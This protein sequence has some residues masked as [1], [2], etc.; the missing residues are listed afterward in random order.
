M[1]IML[2]GSFY[3]F[4]GSKQATRGYH[5][6]PVEVV[7][8]LEGGR[9]WVWKNQVNAFLKHNQLYLLFGMGKSVS[10]VY[11]ESH[12]QYVRNFIETGIIGSLVFFFLI[13]MILKK[14][15]HEFARGKD[16]FLVALCAGAFVSTLA[17]LVMAIAAEVFLS[18]KIDEIYWSLT[19]LTM[20]V[21]SLHKEKRIIE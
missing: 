18:V 5:L 17:M 14:T 1:F 9:T 12:S 16:P 19:A 7:A 6:N 13:G 21:I 10:P 8:G 2:A 3:Y 20:A 15:L 4:I 11:E